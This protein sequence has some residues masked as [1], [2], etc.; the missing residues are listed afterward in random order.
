MFSKFFIQRP[1]F[2]IVIA[3]LMVLVGG[4]CYYSLPVS[5]YPNI[6]P[7]TVMVAASYPGADAQTVANTVGAPLE[8]Q[9]NGVEGM[10]Y[11]SS[12]SGSDGS[13]ML[14]I[15]FE[16]GTDIDDATVKVQNRVSQVQPT[17]PEDVLQEGVTVSS[18]SSEM[19]MFVALEGD[20]S[21]GYDALYLTNYANLNINDRLSRVDGVGNVQAFGGGDYS[22][23]VWLDPQKMYEK[24][25][26]ATEIMAAI[27]S[28]NVDVSAG[29][30]GTQPDADNAQFQFTL[31]S[32][33]MLKSAEEFGNIIIKVGEDGGILRLK[34]L[35]K[36]ELGSTTYSN[37]ANV[38]GKQTALIGINQ[39]SDAN[40]ID[41]EKGVKKALEEVS[42]YFPEGV[43]YRILMDSTDYI[44]ESMD[45]LAM[46][47]AE[48]T[49]IVMLVILIFLQSWRAVIIPMLTIPV[50]LIATFAVMKLLGFSS[51]PSPSSD[52]C[53]P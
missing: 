17:L 34:D 6:T 50:S 51:T 48:T 49:L 43:H 1:I 16:N 19:L 24:N 27:R 18:R 26:T 15:T 25:L 31:T 44:S 40:A 41:V 22:M 8:E 33:G 37:V 11:M 4:L 52:L 12:S 3:I 38:N 2:A 21:K 39:R 28:Q 20:D 53:L 29:S 46:T 7:P 30:T 36:V 14:T 42:K 9:I 23:R 45:D 35:G 10:M 5:Q 32:G 13:Y 47:F